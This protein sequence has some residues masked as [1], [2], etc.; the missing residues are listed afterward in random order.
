MVSSP[1]DWGM[2]WV[3]ERNVHKG[4]NVKEQRERSRGER[5]FAA[6]DDSNESAPPA[7]CRRR[8]MAEMMKQRTTGSD[9]EGKEA[10]GQAPGGRSE[11]HKK[12]KKRGN[13]A[14]KNGRR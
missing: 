8:K 1:R 11:K 3:K 12:R 6:A 5:R 7:H 13:G 9:Q 2:V 4:E 14:G 10:R